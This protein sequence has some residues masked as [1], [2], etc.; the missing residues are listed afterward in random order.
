VRRSNHRPRI[1]GDEALALRRLAG[2]L[3]IVILERRKRA[4][5]AAGLDPRTRRQ[6]RDLQPEGAALLKSPSRRDE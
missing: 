3:A 2:Q 6:R 4:F 5:A 1:T